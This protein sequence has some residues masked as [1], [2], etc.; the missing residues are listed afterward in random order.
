M[1]LSGCK[2]LREAVAAANYKITF[3]DNPF[4]KI[5]FSSY[6]SLLNMGGGCPPPIGFLLN[7]A[8][9]CLIYRLKRAW[10]EDLFKRKLKILSHFRPAINQEACRCVSLALFQ[11]GVEWSIFFLFHDSFGFYDRIQNRKLCCILRLSSI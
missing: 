5:S 4:L 1:S 11:H 6:R 9:Q 10:I 2:R 8:L 7:C 3:L